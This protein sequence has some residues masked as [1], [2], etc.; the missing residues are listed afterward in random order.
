MEIL[1]SHK[2]TKF[3]FKQTQILPLGQHTNKQPSMVMHA[4]L[5]YKHNLLHTKNIYKLGILLHTQDGKCMRS[6]K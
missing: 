5:A 1:S 6:N 4:R 2:N 3:Q